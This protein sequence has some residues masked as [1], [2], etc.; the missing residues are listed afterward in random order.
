MPE[1]GHLRTRVGKLSGIDK[2]VAGGRRRR[3]P[4]QVADRGRRIGD[5]QIGVDAV[6]EQA[7]NGTVLRDHDGAVVRAAGDLRDNSN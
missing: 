6:R 2:A 7:A 3:T 4:T 5:T 1:F